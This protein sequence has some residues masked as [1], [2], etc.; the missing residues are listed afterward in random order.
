LTA[1]Q[2]KTV[3]LFGMTAFLRRSELSRINLTSAVIDSDT[4]SL[5]FEIVSPNEIRTGRCIIKFV[6]IHRYS[7][8]ALCPVAD[9]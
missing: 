2:T 9:F 8:P 3:F 1:L 5:F 4:G 6:L 7:N